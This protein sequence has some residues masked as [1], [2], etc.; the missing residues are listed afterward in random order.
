MLQFKNC[1]LTYINTNHELSL[2]YAILESFEFRSQSKSIVLSL[3]LP[4]YYLWPDT[5]VWTL[6]CHITYLHNEASKDFVSRDTLLL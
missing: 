3:F 1:P 2:I 6:L 5:M 4:T